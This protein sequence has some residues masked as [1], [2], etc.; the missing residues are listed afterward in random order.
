MT[1]TR[2]LAGDEGGAATGGAGGKR[3]TIW[4]LDLDL[5]QRVEIL[6]QSGVLERGEV[7]ESGVAL[8]GDEGGVATKKG[9]CL[10]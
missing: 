2:A 6:L 9:P 8:A 5:F 10:G 1:R 4:R 3:G 7:G